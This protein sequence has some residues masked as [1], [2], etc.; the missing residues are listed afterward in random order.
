MRAEVLIVGQGL[1]GTLLAWELGRAGIGFEIVD[2]G[3]A[4][5]A[6]MAAAG[7]INPIT[8]RRLVKSWRV[9]TLLPG[10]RA[11]YREMEA[12]LGVSLWR[13]MRVWR[14][15]ADQRERNVFAAKLASGELAPYAAVGDERGFWINNAG[16]VDLPTMLTAARSA[17]VTRGQLRERSGAAENPDDYELVIDCTGLAAARGGQFGFVPWEFSK[18]EMLEV[19]IDE[20]LPTDVILNGGHWLLPIS[21]RSAWVGASHEPGVVD[22]AVSAQAREVLSGSAA[23]LAGGKFRVI[24]QR[25]GVR[26]NLPDKRPVVGRNPANPRRGL[27]NGLGAKGALW[28]PWLARAWVQHLTERRPFDREVDVQRFAR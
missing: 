10:A 13:D 27:I 18:G 1:A 4:H 17:W 24:G 26:V 5:A 11:T 19:E 21:G 6:T 16:R 7:I 8:G 15:F 14:L 25:A 12:A 3:H 23:R 28:A 2:D 22:V 9:D 20:A